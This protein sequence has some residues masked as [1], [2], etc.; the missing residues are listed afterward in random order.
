MKT[1]KAKRQ[2]R[3]PAWKGLLRFNL[4]SIPVRAFPARVK[5]ASH[6]DLDWLHRDCGER[7]QYRKVCPVHGEVT[8]DEIISA[9]KY[10][11]QRYIE[12]EP[13]ELD[14]LRTKRE[15]AINVETFIRPKDMDPIYFTD[16]TYYLL[17]EDPA[18]A[19]AYHVFQQVMKEQ[20]RFGLAQVVLFKREQMVLL[21][22]YD[23]LLIMTV[24]NYEREFQSPAQLAA[25][26]P[27]VKATASETDLAVQLIEDLTPKE[28]D[29]SEYHD[30][31]AEKLLKLIETKARGRKIE[32]PP[33]EE[34]EPVSL[35][36]TEA[37]KKSIAKAR[38]AARHAHKR[39]KVS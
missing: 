23:S 37:L 18:A 16:R 11:K 5:D 24:L 25:Q 9:Y 28:F 39:R 26:L 17:P 1:R 4:V 14:Q 20:D 21:R 32:P 8:K 12:V 10:H 30:A 34:E 33:E 27:S 3:R 19:R 22:A 38:S 29:Y 36:F 6:I 2:G 15:E 7:I 13:E 35:D 31:Y